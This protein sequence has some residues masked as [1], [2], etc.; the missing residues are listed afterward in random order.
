MQL[1]VNQIIQDKQAVVSKKDNAKGKEVVEMEISKG[2]GKKIASGRPRTRATKRAFEQQ[3]DI[4]PPK[5]KIMV[6]DLIARNINED[7]V[8]WLDKVNGYLEKLLKKANKNNNLQ[9]HMVMHYYTRNKISQVKIKQLKS[10]LK[11]NLIGKKDKDSLEILA[12][13]SL[14]A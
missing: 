4:S 1:K 3:G 2:K 9:R 11:E 5:E 14:I 7:K 13:A 10:K 8:Y 6:D 12:E